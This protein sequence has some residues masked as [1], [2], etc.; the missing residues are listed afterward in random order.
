MKKI[1]KK[2]SSKSLSQK[3]DKQGS[4]SNSFIRS[5]LLHNNNYHDKIKENTINDDY[6]PSPGRSD[7][8]NIK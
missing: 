4:L 5:S 8:K 2:M 3:K 1:S 7:T 6:F